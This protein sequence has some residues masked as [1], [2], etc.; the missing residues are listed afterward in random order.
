MQNDNESFISLRKHDYID[1]DGNEQNPIVGTSILLFFGGVFGL[2]VWI[3]G[4]NIIWKD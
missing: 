3:T 4:I 2:I 1:E